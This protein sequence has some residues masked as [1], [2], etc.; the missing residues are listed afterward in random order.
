MVVTRNYPYVEQ[1]GTQWYYWLSQ[2][3]AAKGP[4]ESMQ[5]ANDAMTAEMQTRH[6]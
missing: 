2:W 3:E 1:V 6:G 4:F 5:A